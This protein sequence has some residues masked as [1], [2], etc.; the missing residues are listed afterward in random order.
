MTPEYD[1]VDLGFTTADAEQVKLDFDG[2]DLILHCIDWEEE[3]VR[4]TFRGVLAYCW[5]QHLGTTQVRDDEAYEVRN[6][7]WLVRE[8]KLASVDADSYA[9]YKVCFNACGVLDVLALKVE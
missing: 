1:R 9:H 5:G 4:H 2:S 8:A 6:S 7:P 3:P